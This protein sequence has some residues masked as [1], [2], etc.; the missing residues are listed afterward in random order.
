MTIT[1]T[2]TESQ[3]SPELAHTLQN[4]NKLQK[5][6][7]N[8][9]KSNQNTPNT[10][11]TQAIKKPALLV[12]N[13]TPA[14]TKPKSDTQISTKSTQNTT[15]TTTLSLQLKITPQPKK[16]SSSP[17][18]RTRKKSAP[19]QPSGGLVFKS[20]VGWVMQ[21][22]EKVADSGNQSDEGEEDEE[23]DPNLHEYVNKMQRRSSKLTLMT[24]EMGMK[25]FMTEPGVIKPA[26]FSHRPVK[27]MQRNIEEYLRRWLNGQNFNK[28]KSECLGTTCVKLAFFQAI[29]KIV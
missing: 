20:G 12:S 17:D 5:P 28:Y 14:Q 6:A 7:Q 16:L 15:P 23:E 24:P 22:A 25:A 2:K 1:E 19:V 3:K 21:E 11:N 10:K 18:L 27:L 29:L 13:T 4:T 9:L 8:T 26:P